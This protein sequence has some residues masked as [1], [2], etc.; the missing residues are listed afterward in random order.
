MP[1]IATVFDKLNQEYKKYLDAE[2]SY[3]MVSCMYTRGRSTPPHPRYIFNVTKQIL[4][5]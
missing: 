5:E 2:Q 4:V 3:T 1:V